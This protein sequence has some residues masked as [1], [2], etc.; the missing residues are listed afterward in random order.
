MAQQK[1][2]RTLIMGSGFRWKKVFKEVTSTL[3]WYINKGWGV[4]E[5]TVSRGWFRVVVVVAVTIPP[6]EDS[7]PTAPPEEEMND[8]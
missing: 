3:N 4:E 5:F 2:V 7:K 1:R 8:E 6:P